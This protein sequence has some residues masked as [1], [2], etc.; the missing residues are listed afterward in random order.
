MALDQGIGTCGKDGQWV[1][2]GVGQPTLLIDGPDGRRHR[3]L[4]DP[5]G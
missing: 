3:R 5:T 2:V 1:P 4:T